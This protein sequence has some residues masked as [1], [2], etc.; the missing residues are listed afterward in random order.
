MD[1]SYLNRILSGNFS[2]NLMKLFVVLCLCGVSQVGGS[3]EY[4]ITPHSDGAYIPVSV[5]TSLPASSSVGLE[6]PNGENIKGQIADGRILWL[7]PEAKAGQSQKW[8]VGQRPFLKSDSL[9]FSIKNNEKSHTD[10]LFDG[11]PVSRLMTAFDNSTKDSAFETY[12][13]YSHI[14]KP[15]GTNFITKGAHGLFAH[16]RGIFIGWSN[17][18]FDGKRIDS[19]HMNGAVQVFK[20]LNSSYSGQIAANI[21]PKILWNT[22]SGKTFIEETRSLT[23]FNQPSDNS[24]VFLD[25]VSTLKAPN[26]EVSLSGDPEH[27]GIQ[28]RPN[29]EL[30]KLK[31]AQFTFHQ[32]SINPKKDKNLPWVLLTFQLHGETYHVQHLTHNS[33]PKDYMYSAYRDYG[34]FGAFPQF[35]I[36]N[37]ES[38]QLKFRF[39]ITKGPKPTIQSLHHNYIHFTSPPTISKI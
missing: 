38:R 5:P 16:H 30:A 37:G 14:F 6:G 15:D 35:T 9:G 28:F 31:N 26:G 10:I 33:T 20:A 3:Q 13:V 8:I 2:Q 7:L 32:P 21:S 29:N 17:T 25:F 1:S 18:R 27:A 19:W 12:K 11:K 36:P 22:T 24:V 34:R 4:Q 23:F 39:I